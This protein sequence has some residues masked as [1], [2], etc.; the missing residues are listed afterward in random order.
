MEW[1]E[2]SVALT[3][4]DS[5]HPARAFYNLNQLRK[6]NRLCD[7]DIKVRNA[8]LVAHKAILATNSPYILKLLNDNRASIVLDDPLLNV[9]AVDTLFEFIYTS[10]LRIAKNNVQPLCY[11]AKCLQMERIERACCKFMSKNVS[12][13]CV[14]YYRF[15]RTHG[16][17]GLEQRCCEFISSHLEIISVAEMTADE[18]AAVLRRERLALDA[19]GV[20][21]VISQWIA[22]DFGAR[23]EHAWRLLD[24]VRTPWLADVCRDLSHSARDTLRGRPMGSLEP[25]CFFR[26]LRQH[27]ATPKHLGRARQA[28]SAGSSLHTRDVRQEPAGAGL[29]PFATYQPSA[30]GSTSASPT[31]ANG[32][33]H[34][35]ASIRTDASQA[36]GRS[37]EHVLRL[38]SSAAPG[39][40]TGS[41]MDIAR[42]ASVGDISPQKMLVRTGTPVRVN[43]PKARDQHAT[44]PDMII[45]TVNTSPLVACAPEILVSTDTTKISSPPDV[46]DHTPPLPSAMPVQDHISLKVPKG[47]DASDKSINCTTVSLN[48]ADHLTPPGTLVRG[49]STHFTPTDVS[50][51]SSPIQHNPELEVSDDRVGAAIMTLGADEDHTSPPETVATA[52]SPQHTVVTPETSP[53]NSSK[54][55]S[56]LGRSQSSS[57]SVASPPPKPLS[58]MSSLN[59]P[60]RLEEATA[61]SKCF[62]GH[63]PPPPPPAADGS[64]IAGIVYVAGGSTSMS[65]SASVEKYSPATG[66]WTQAPNLPKKRSHCALAYAGKKLYVLGGMGEYSILTSVDVYDPHVGRWQEGPQ[67]PRPKS[68]FG[69]AVVGTTIYCIGGSDGTTDLTSVEIF[70]LHSNRWKQGSSLLQPRSYVQAAVLDG[71][72]YVVGGS[73]EAT[74]LSTV[75]RLQGMNGTWEAVAEMNTPRSRPAVASL[76]G[77]MYAVGGYNGTTILRS[78]ECYTPGVDQWTMVASMSTP[79]NSPGIAVVGT[80][81]LVCGGYNGK[82][83][84]SSCEFYDPAGDKWLPAATMCTARCNFGTTVVSPVVV[85]TWL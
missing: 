5:S 18:M 68:N 58:A 6:A 75:E 85:N 12:G 84:V 82:S 41:A 16:Y 36:T 78:A 4:R 70:D 30:A 59:L 2:D 80:R 22:H 65:V 29:Y 77:K 15:A 9:Q 74:R 7:I 81:L 51:E 63:V 79:R 11:A 60:V 73:R 1:T 55:V 17:E 66:T 32:C 3:L 54:H 52:R 57:L 45:G 24:S 47:E 43:S 71:T 31:V 10:V 64:S 34:G 46:R 25:E 28:W 61:K 48:S 37:A 38:A 72:V 26:A 39:I 42:K 20:V 23:V 13:D 83:I 19:D 27:M 62:P 56:A 40:L 44:I 14:S 53:K 50:L 67:M 8:T 69:V 33:V 76:C 35:S 21:R 49:S